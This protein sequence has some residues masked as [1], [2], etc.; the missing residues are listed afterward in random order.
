[1]PVNRRQICGK[2]PV[3]PQCDTGFFVFDHIGSTS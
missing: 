2:E 3:L 1:M